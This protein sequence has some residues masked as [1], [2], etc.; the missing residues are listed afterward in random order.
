[1]EH[2]S[3]RSTTATRALYSP[4][5]WAVAVI[6]AFFGVIYYGDHVNIPDFI[7]FA[8]AFFTTEYMHDVHR[9]LLLI[10]MLYT[11]LVFQRKGAIVISFACFGIVLPRAVFLSPY[12]DAIPRALIFIALAS[13]ATV[14]LGMEQKRRKSLN[15]A[16]AKLGAAHSELESSAEQLMASEKRY[17]DLFQGAS[18]AVVVSDPEYNIVEANRSMV[19]LAG[20]SLTELQGMNIKQLFAREDADEAVPKL[21]QWLNGEAAGHRYEERMIKKDGTEL[22]VEL[23]AQP[24]IANGR[25][26]AIQTMARDVTEERR[27]QQNMEFYI[28]EIT[29]AQE[30]ERKRIARELHDET[31]Q[32][33]AALA[34]QIETIMRHVQKV[35]NEALEQ[36]EQ[37]MEKTES[38]M[39]GVRRFSHELR[40]GLLDHLGLVPALDWLTTETKVSYGIDAS[41]DIIGAERRLSPEIELVL[42]RIGQEAL[43]NA[44]HHSEATRVVVEIEFG[45]EKVRLCVTDNGKGF[46]LPKMLGDFAARRKLG[47][48]G[49][50]ERARII[51]GSFLLQSE[52]GS[53]TTVSVEVAA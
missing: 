16:Y 43:N 30:E 53:G 42:F 44:R 20:Y 31:A 29:Q 52:A 40:P 9:A 6:T 25:L 41:I 1:M 45:A 24:I 33:L 46:E 34:L 19:T 4:H 2:S 22:I 47:I 12:P 10:P 38:L 21:Y 23:A 14:L 26:I 27:L 11:A 48:L 18:E 15:K 36:L 13:L 8:K 32:G 35:P 17:R 49:M 37:L 5:L 7:P 39:E 3:P 28:S 51:G 50:Q